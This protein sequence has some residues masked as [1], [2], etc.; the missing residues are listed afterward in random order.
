MR[1]AGI[2]AG[3]GVTWAASL[4]G[5]MAALAGFESTVNWLGTFVL[6]LIPG[7]A[8]GALLGWAEAERRRGRR[9]SWVAFVPLVFPVVA[10]AAPGALVAFLRT[11]I[12]GG[13][14][15]LVVTAMLLGYAISGRGPRVA[16]IL[17]GV[18]ATLGLAGTALGGVLVR[19]QLA[20]TTPRGLWVAILGVGLTAVFGA[21]CSIPHRAPR[22]HGS[23]L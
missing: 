18:V 21:A 5:Y 6:I 13:S 1:L 8:V 17:T 9:R 19:S 15:A 22:R 10:L 3:L 16:R 7:A 2:G 12:G 4:R 11:G 23:E 14:I 20:I